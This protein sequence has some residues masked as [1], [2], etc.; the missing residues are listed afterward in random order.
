MNGCP[1]IAAMSAAFIFSAEHPK[2]Y[3]TSA[4]PRVSY[5]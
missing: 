2:I 1:Y 4:P 3:E 5:I